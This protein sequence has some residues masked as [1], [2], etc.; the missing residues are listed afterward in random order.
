MRVNQKMKI[1]L[2]LLFVT[3]S[4]FSFGQKPSFKWG[5]KDRNLITTPVASYGLNDSYVVLGD[6]S[7]LK[8]LSEKETIVTRM[9]KMKVLESES[10]DPLQLIHR[11]VVQYPINSINCTVFTFEFDDTQNVF[12]TKKTLESNDFFK[13]GDIN[14][15]PLQEITRTGDV[16]EF[17]YQY[18]V[19]YL[20]NFQ[21]AGNAD[22]STHFA[23]IEISQ[24]SFL[25]VTMESSDLSF[26]ESE[27]SVER[28]TFSPDTVFNLLDIARVEYQGIVSTFHSK[29]WS[30]ANPP[31]VDFLGEVRQQINPHNL[32]EYKREI[33][34][35][36]DVVLSLDHPFLN[37]NPDAKGFVFYDKAVN[38][39]KD[40][41]FERE[42]KMVVLK[43]EG[44]F[45]GDF[46]TPVTSGN[47]GV[48]EKIEVVVYA[49]KKGRYV[50]SEIDK[51]AIFKVRLGPRSHLYRFAAPNVK[52]GSFIFVKYR[53]SNF[54]LYDW[55]FQKNVPVGLSEYKIVAPE[56]VRFSKKVLGNIP[57]DY[58]EK[59][60][61]SYV[62]T[63]EHTF[64]AV[65][66]PAFKSEPFMA[67]DR[68]YR[69]SVNLS[70]TGVGLFDAWPNWES[71]MFKL[72][73][74]P[75]FGAFLNCHP[76]MKKEVK[77]LK[78]QI[79]DEIE[80]AKAIRN[81]VIDNFTWNE[82]LGV[83]SYD[84]K[85][86][87]M[88][89]RSGNVAAI[90]LTLISMLKEAGLNA[91]PVVMQTRT[92]G[93][94][95][96]A[97][98][99]QNDLN[100]L[101]C[102]LK[103]EDNLLLLDATDK[104]ASFSMLPERALNYF[105]VMFG[106]NTHQV[107]E[108]PGSKTRK[109]VVY[110][111]A[112]L[113]LDGAFSGTVQR[114]YDGYSGYQIRCEIDSTSIARRQEKLDESFLFLALDDYDLNLGESKSRPVKERYLVSNELDLSSETIFNPILLPFMSENPLKAETRQHPI[115][116]PQTEDFTYIFNL[117]IPD[118]I[119]ISPLPQSEITY[120]SE[121]GKDGMLKV[122][123]NQTSNQ[124]QIT[125]KVLV[126]KDFF[127][128]EEYPILRNFYDEII[129]VCNTSI[130]ISRT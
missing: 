119:V 91:R 79:K 33:S 122:L 21:W 32:D 87:F 114:S 69:S 31:K 17:K 35:S 12:L 53:L 49:K 15:S 62:T 71:A 105:G 20:D 112:K 4:F 124:I 14:F 22:A 108:I 103:I 38:N 50:K 82:R 130:S 30:L 84:A 45:L 117:S 113:E 104:H 107:V 101:L 80:L 93:P 65:N 27:T 85:G 23:E 86:K 102:G 24:P 25:Q 59:S 54:A 16:I 90:N 18:S 73:E 39:L 72:N 89:L 46:E 41:F 67:S 56:A 2:N 5:V 7:Y 63:N 9:M 34:Y 28:E 75:Y 76:L 106:E 95:D 64:T 98:P 118:G 44:T 110:I 36:E 92:S 100:Y 58:E 60:I 94:M 43:P 116:L 66:V 48:T 51:E 13:N 1:Y 70:L 97:M 42:M 68:N 115:D 83:A 3:V 126:V 57:V 52:E 61:A 99:K 19:T 29:K 123:Y 129:K 81:Y 8:V 74:S 40:G 96:I 120:L 6:Y 47:G 128:P 55:T 127:L 121:D 26:K 109:E 77:L 11:D 37:E 125:M 78:T 10:F 88:K 111:N